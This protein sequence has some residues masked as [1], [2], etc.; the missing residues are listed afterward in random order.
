MSVCG[1]EFN[2]TQFGWDWC[3]KKINHKGDHYDS[4]SGNSCPNK[5]ESGNKQDEDVKQPNQRDSSERR[6]LF[7]PHDFE[8]FP[9]II[10]GN[11]RICGGPIVEPW[12]QAKPASVQE[13][14]SDKEAD[15]KTCEHCDGNGGWLVNPDWPM[16]DCG[17]RDWVAC[18]HCDS[19]DRKDELW[20]EHLRQYNHARFGSPL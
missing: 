6:P 8:G 1:Y 5:G 13:I 10:G 14:V 19:P 7:E 17:D 15:Q 11:C 18:P 4:A 20:R 12:H 2:V 3:T 9:G 16:G